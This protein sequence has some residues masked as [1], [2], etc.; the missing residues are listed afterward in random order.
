MLQDRLR[1]RAAGHALE[2]EEHSERQC[3][4][5]SSKGG[6][7][8]AVSDT[9]GDKFAEAPIPTTSERGVVCYPAAA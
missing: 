8:G 9:V 2:K 5:A 7:M 4:V 3:V 6:R 1:I